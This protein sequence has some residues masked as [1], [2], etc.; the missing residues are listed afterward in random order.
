MER[1]LAVTV[2]G[3]DRPGIV[4]GIT[5]ALFDL[6]C[7]LE[8]V[9]S[10]IL[11]GHFTM[12]LIVHAPMGV[13][14]AD[15]ESKLAP[16]ARQM[17]LIVRVGEV[18]DAHEPITPPT[19]VVSVYGADRPGLVFR[20]AETLASRAVNITDLRSRVLDPGDGGESGYVVMLEVVAPEGALQDELDA[21]RR[22]M[23]VEISVNRIDPELL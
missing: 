13:S 1:T 9:N 3:D 2:I 4:A 19:H 8:D 22:D 5:K 20:V 17:N 21:L 12:M 18:S 15:A 16:A 23:D 6:G 11:R 7:N 10:A 14:A